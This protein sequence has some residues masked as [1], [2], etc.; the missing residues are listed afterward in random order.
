[1]SE[2]ATVLNCMDGRVQRKVRDYLKASFGARFI[3]TVTA[4]GMVKNLAATTGRTAEIL[5]DSR[6]STVRHGSTQ[7][8]VAAHADCAGNPIPDAAQK[9]QLGEAMARLRHEFPDADIVALWLDSHQIVER[10]RS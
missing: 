10:I 2:F 3:D 7:I 8:A 1:M 6:V 9:K 4:P 5:T